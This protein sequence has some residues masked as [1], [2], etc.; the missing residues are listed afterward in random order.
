MKNNKEQDINIILEKR[1]NEMN[2]HIKQ[3]DSNEPKQN[4]EAIIVGIIAIGLYVWLMFFFTDVI[5]D[6]ETIIKEQ[7]KTIQELKEQKTRK[8]PLYLFDSNGQTTYK[9]IIKEK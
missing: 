7:E 9:L 8:I 1:R 5:K 4:V 2:I 3:P 6:K